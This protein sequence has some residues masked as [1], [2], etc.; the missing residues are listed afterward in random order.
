MSTATATCRTFRLI[1][2]LLSI[3]SASSQENNANTLLLNE[4]LSYVDE[5]VSECDDYY[6]Y[7]CGKWTEV[8]ENDDFVDPLGLIDQKVNGNLVKLMAE[9]QQKQQRSNVEAKMLS[10]YQTC[11]QAANSTRASKGYLEL[12]PP[13]E[14]ILWPQ[15]K[16]RWEDWDSSKF[17]WMET[18]ARLRRYGLAN[19]LFDLDLQT[20]NNSKYLVVIE[21]P[22]LKTEST[23]LPTDLHVLSQKL[24]VLGV[25]DRETYSLARQVTM[26]EQGVRKLV[27]NSQSSET[28]G[29]ITVHELEQQT[30]G[31]WRKYFEILLNRTVS[32]DF[33]LQVQNV[34]Y[35]KQLNRTLARWNAEVLASYIM[36]RFVSYLEEATMDS[37]EPIDCVQE[38]RRHMLLATNLIYEQ[39]FIGPD[40]LRKLQRDVSELLEVLRQQFYKMLKFNHL[41][42]KSNQLK[43]LRDKMKMMKLSFGSMPMHTNHSSIV[44]SFYEDLQLLEDRD[45]AKNLL[46]LLEFDTR[47]LFEQLDKPHDFFLPDP[48]MSMISTP[49]YIRDQNTIVMPFGVLEEPFFQPDAHDIFKTTLLGHLSHELMHGFDSSGL[50]YDRDGNYNAQIHKI[51]S[52]RL[53]E[54]G[55]S[56]LN[57]YETVGMDEREADIAGIRLAYDAYFGPGSRF[58]QSQPSFTSLSLKQL[59]FL[60][61]MQYFC[62]KEP[63]NDDEEHDSDDIRVYQMLI[64]LPAFAEAHGC[65]PDDD[66]MH[67]SAKCRLW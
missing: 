36:L 20:E 6:R 27:L 64:N 46:R 51:T 13:N 31:D 9:L 61:S 12:V 65:R 7:A 5:S 24:L 37:R 49:F 41:G 8:H 2:I 35:L 11:R 48:N 22:K 4:I 56:C 15:F 19:V 43:L 45:Y 55:I 63:L 57:Q 53:H 28:V 10:F 3:L 26:L 30:G 23:Q 58:N 18:L 17:Q 59:F 44:S 47:R 16:R 34:A 1:L 60:N 40:K 25:N 21:K 38:L 66:N 14:Q 42:L 50:D 52:L 67:P 62:N 32:A 33:V 29:E 39:R 54:A